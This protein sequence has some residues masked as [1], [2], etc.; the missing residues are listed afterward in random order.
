MYFNQ[1]S[2]RPL[3]V[4]R[5]GGFTLIEMLIVVAVIAILVA[6][7]IPIVSS[8]LNKTKIATDM[9]NERSAKAAAT[10]AYLQEDAKG[11]SYLFDAETGTLVPVG[12]DTVTGYGKC[13]DHKDY[14]L[15]LNISKAGAITMDWYPSSGD[16]DDPY[17][18]IDGV[19][20]PHNLSDAEN[21][22][23]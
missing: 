4:R 21:A 7:A 15:F 17:F 5:C 1:K 14:Y 22:A 16:M 18:W 23:D 11:Q 19:R 12:T 9:A 13:S 8:A 2:A 3:K 10:L 6:V 20:S